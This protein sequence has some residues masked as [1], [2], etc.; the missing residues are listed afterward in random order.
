MPSKKHN[1]EFTLKA[2]NDL[3]D[4]A[5]YYKFKVGPNSARKITDAILD[6]IQMLCDFPE[7]GAKPKV[8]QIAD[9][10]YRFI[11]VKEYLCFYTIFEHT[12]FIHHI[13]HRSANY[14]KRIF[15]D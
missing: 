4:I 8:Q 13:I 15:T 12:V 9:S 5:T 1:V 11:V 6:K 10:G 7:M 14:I 3:R 2:Q